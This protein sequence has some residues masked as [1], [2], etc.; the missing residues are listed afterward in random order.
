MALIFLSTQQAQLQNKVLTP[1]SLVASLEVL[2]GLSLTGV[3]VETHASHDSLWLPGSLG[4]CI[5][6]LKQARIQA[7]FVTFQLCSVPRMSFFNLL[8]YL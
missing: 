8:V 4:I 6:R 2:L 3:S 7:H 5:S 1:Q